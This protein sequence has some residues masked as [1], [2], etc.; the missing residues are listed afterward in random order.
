MSSLLSRGVCVC[1][2]VCWGLCV[3]KVVHK[4]SEPGGVEDSGRGCG[5][6][7]R[8]E[9]Y[10]YRLVTSI[11]LFSRYQYPSLDQLADMIPCILQYLK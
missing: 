2:C 6:C 8:E 9:V 11:F 4:C 10:E 1:W 7:S 5:G 3:S